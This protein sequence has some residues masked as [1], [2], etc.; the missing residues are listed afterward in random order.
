MKIK[1]KRVFSVRINYH[2]G[3]IATYNVLALDDVKARAIAVKLSGK[4]F[5]DNNLKAPEVEYCETKFVCETQ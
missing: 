4:D 1:M 5:E 2:G 3:T